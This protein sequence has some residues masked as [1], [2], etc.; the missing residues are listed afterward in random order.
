MA[1]VSKSIEMRFTEQGLSS[2]IEKTSTLQRNFTRLDTTTKTTAGGVQTFSE[3][4]TQLGGKFG[5]LGGALNSTMMRFI[6]LNAVISMGSQAYHE[7]RQ[8]VDESVQSFRSFEYKMAEVSSILDAQTRYTLPGLEVGI[9]NLSVK[10]GKSVEDMTKGLYDI[11]SAAFGVKDAIGLLEVSTRAAIAGVTSTTSAVNTIT[12]VLNAYGMSAAMAAQ[13]SDALFQSVIRGV[14][15]FSDLEGALGYVTPI[16]AGLGVALDEVLSAMSSATRQGQHLDSVTRGLGLLL[17]GIVDPTTQASDAAKKYGIDMSATSLRVN[18]LTGFLKQLSEATQKYGMQILPELIGNMRS[19]RVAIAL[20][21]ETGITGFNE[22]MELMATATGRTDDAMAAMMNTAKMMADILEQSMAKVERVVGESMSGIDLWW[23]KSMV[24]W[25]AEL[26]KPF[27]GAGNKAVAQIDKIFSDI[28]QSYIDNLIAPTDTGEKTILDKL[29]EGVSVK[30][31]IPWDIIAKY[32]TTSESLVGV[33]KINKAASDAKV[34]LEQ[35]KAAGNASGAAIPTVPASEN[36]TKLN[37]LLGSIGLADKMLKVGNATQGMGD[38]FTALDNIIATTNGSLESLI[39]T[40]SDLRPVVDGVKA[41]FDTQKLSIIDLNLSVIMIKGEI[42]AL[43]EQLNVKYKGSENILEYGFAVKSASNDLER[44]AEYSKM[45]QS[46]GP[47]YLN[48]FTNQTD[49]YDHSMNAVLTT[50]YEY[51]EAMVEQK[52]VTE[53]AERANRDL[54]I[55]MAFN[56]IQMLKYQLIGMIRRRGN[57][58]SEQKAMKQLEIENTKL[59]IQEMQNQ[60]NADVTN[61]DAT[62]SEQQAAYDE[63]QEIL[64][65]YIEFEQHE[66]WVLQDSRDEDLQ[67]LRD[68]IDAQRTLLETKTTDLQTENKKLLDAY[69][70]FSGGLDIIASDPALAEMYKELFG[71]NAAEDAMAALAA[72][73]AFQASSG[74]TPPAASTG[75]N[76]GNTSQGNIGGVIGGISTPVQDFVNQ[77]F[78]IRA[79]GYETGTNYVPSTGLYQLHKGE[80]VIPA[81]QNGGGISIGNISITIPVKTNASPNDIAKAVT[82]ALDAQILKYDSTGRLVSKYRRR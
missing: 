61:N 53:E 66:L 38:I 29:N 80:A 5:Q 18:G 62:N 9:T 73:R 76:G 8:F 71:T 60:Y 45:A 54:E 58:R 2:I 34:I 57:T 14:Y 11:V 16:A 26:G 20:T 46:Q 64:S 27:S 55:Q 78:A 31:A 70:L 74:A 37:E 24:Y 23:K 52:K 67:S 17:Q 6:G 49:Q 15:T 63:A 13:V 25:A 77:I 1:D 75:G 56:N 32:E 42:E 28:R 35:I 12:G 65:N 82:M 33:N 22:D 41:A 36:L 30:T 51:N 72:L 44:F 4:T 50:I 40:E 19:L 69:M 47:E 59:R 81:G 48:E 7:L 10:Y 68:N 3:K 43:N 79:R 21:S 39:Q